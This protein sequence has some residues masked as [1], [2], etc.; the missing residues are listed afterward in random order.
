MS[1]G[2][3]SAVIP[4]TNFVPAAPEFRKTLCPPL[5]ANF[6]NFMILEGILEA[7]SAYGILEGFRGDWEDEDVIFSSFKFFC[8]AG[9]KRRRRVQE[10]SGKR[11]IQLSLPESSFPTYVRGAENP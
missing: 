7:N 6:A 9:L 8:I 10:G 2:D 3:T 11:G 1:G 4:P 5:S